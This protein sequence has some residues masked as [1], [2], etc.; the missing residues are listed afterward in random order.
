MAAIPN[1]RLVLASAS[2]RRLDLLQRV[3]ITPSDVV[4]ANVDETPRKNEH[5]RDLAERLAIA[6]ASAVAS[7]P[8]GKGVF[9]L[10]AD[11]VVA[12][13]R[14][15]LPK[16]ETED[17]ARTCLEILSG[18][19]HRV[20]GGF[21]LVTPTGT[22]NS[23]VV[24]TMVHMKTLTSVET[25]DYI[26]SGD[27]HGKAGGYAIQGRAARFVQKING[28]YPNVVGLPV[29]DVVNMLR[30]NGYPVDGVVSDES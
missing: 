1:S 3:G 22:L 18:R 16:A 17:E 7:D 2:P 24:V 12:C 9:V 8:Q 25:A 30:G 29:H 28:S 21:C 11:T 5:P 26:V 20:Y 4:A 6:K 14:R 13:G 27:W 19:R 15:I 23:R 10:G